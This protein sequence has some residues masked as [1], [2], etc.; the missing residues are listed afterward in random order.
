MKGFDLWIPP[1]A[2]TFDDGI[3]VYEIIGNDAQFVQFPLKA[4]RSVTCF[5]GA[6]AYMSDHVKMEVEFG[7]IGQTFGRLAGGGSL[8]KVNYTN[9]SETEDGYISMTPDY[10]GVIIPI[11][12]KEHTEIVALR[13]SY[14]C[15][16]I[17]QYEQETQVGADLFKPDGALA[18]CCSGFDFIVQTINEGEWAF[19]VAMGTVIT[20]NLE[21]GESILVDSNSLLC[22]EKNVSI[23]VER[24]GGICAMFCAGEGLFYTELTGPG[25]VWMQSMSIDKLRSLFPPKTNTT[26]GGGDGDDGGD[27]GDGGGE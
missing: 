17:P 27:G 25:K 11:D 4:G 20:K 15:S 24:V 2:N 7:G 6:M 13:D 14:L 16:T 12:M 1:V 18:F 19:L 26:G 9:E 8:M 10:P 3:P 22:F 5:S 23:N 21:A